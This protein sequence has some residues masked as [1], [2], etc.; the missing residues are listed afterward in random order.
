MKR[1]KS[2]VSHAAS[3]SAWWAVFDWLSIVAALR[4]E[5]HGPES[6]SAARRNTAT[7]SCH[8]VEAHPACAARAA[9]IARSTCEASPF[10]TSA[11]TWS[12]SCGMTASNVVPVSTRSPPITSGIESRSPDISAEPPLQLRPLGRARRVRPNGLVDR[13]GRAEDAGCAHG[14]DCRVGPVD[15]TRHRYAVEGWGVGEILVRD[16]LLVAHALPSRQRRLSPRPK[17]P[18][19]GA[20]APDVTLAANPSRRP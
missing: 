6:S 1:R 13:G 5:R 3:I 10:A 2:I 8:G 9:A 18:P 11:S 19:G 14:A 15:V 17:G 4:V 7:R 16:G 20:S 12:R